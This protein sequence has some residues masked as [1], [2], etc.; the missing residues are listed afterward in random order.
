MRW[1][2]LFQQSEQ[3][4]CIITLQDNTMIGSFLPSPACKAHI[5]LTY[6]PPCA[7][8]CLCGMGN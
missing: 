6:P 5:S 8:A 2:F 7:V 1:Q 4:D 3:F